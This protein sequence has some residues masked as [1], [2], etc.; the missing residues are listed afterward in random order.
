MV[1][2]ADG[3]VLYDT[4]PAQV[5]WM[6]F[7]DPPYAARQVTAERYCT[8]TYGFV[9]DGGEAVQKEIA[10]TTTGLHRSKWRVA[11][12]RE[13]EW[14]N[15]EFVGQTPVSLTAT[16]VGNLQDQMIGSA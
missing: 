16:F 1:V 14:G 8:A 11:V 3:R 6:T 12:I 13:V 4:D 5:G 15:M 10:W 7:A 2:Q 9:A